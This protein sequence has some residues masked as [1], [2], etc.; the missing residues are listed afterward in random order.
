MSSRLQGER[1]HDRELQSKSDEEVEAAIA[2]LDFSK[3]GFEYALAA[4]ISQAE[5]L[6]L[7]TLTEAHARADWSLW[8]KAIHE[9]LEILRATGTWVFGATPPNANVVGS[10]CVFKAKKDAAGNVVRYKARLVAQGYSQVPSID[11]F[12]TYHPLQSSHPFELFWQLL[13]VRTWSFTRSTSKE[14]TSM[15][16]YMTTR[17][18]ICARHYFYR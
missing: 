10:K 9:E 17:S 12:N 5:A 4:E 14:L 2:A 7:R 18:Y 16:I 8:N 15:A 1:G 13:I 11:Y 6:E 3:D